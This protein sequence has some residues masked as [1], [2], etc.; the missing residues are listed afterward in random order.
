LPNKQPI[1]AHQDARPPQLTW[2]ILLPLLIVAGGVLA[3]WNSFAGVFIFDDRLWIIGDRRL[4][5]LW[6]LWEVLG[7]RRPVVDYSLALNRAIGGD[8]AWGFHAVNLTIHVLAG[9]ALFGIVRR[10]LSREPL[11]RRFGASSWWLATVVGLLWVVHPLQ[12]QSVNYII[13]RA[14]S[15]M[16]LFY[17]LTL[18]CVIRGTG[19]RH[20][21]WWYAAAVVASLLG[22][23]SK[24]VMVTAPLAIL[25]YDRAFLAA[26]WREVIQRRWG[27]YVALAATWGVLV[28]TGVARGVL[29]PGRPGAHV[30]FSYR[31][32]SPLGYALTQ[33]GVLLQYLKLSLLPYSLCLDYH[34]PVA[35][36][37]GQ[38]VP[39]GIALA[40]LLAATV[41]ALI[42]YP[43]VG[44]AAAWFFIVLAPTSSMIPIKDPIFEHRMYLPLASIVVLAVIGSDEALCR[45]AAR[46][47]HRDIVRRVAGAA[48][49]V[50][51]AAALVYGTIERNRVYRSEVTMWRDVL[52]KQPRNARAAENLGIS[53]LAEG[54]LGEALET[55]QE[56][57][58]ISPRSANVRN[59]LGFALVAH[60]R[61]DEAI[62]SFREAIRLKPRY[63]RALVNLGNA[64]NEKGR[65]EESIAQFTQAVLIQPNYT[66]ARLNLGN[67]YLTLGNVDDA[68]AQYT[69]IVEFDPEHAKAW[70]NLGY[71]LL[72]QAQRKIAGGGVSTDQAMFD[73]AI[74]ALE[75][76]LDL[77]PKSRNAWNN[78]GLAC[79]MQSEVARSRGDS[80]EADRKLDEAIEAFRQAL[81]VQSDFVAAHYNLA[82]ALAERG[83]DEGAIRHYV[84][85]L[86][87]EPRHLNA[88]YE[89]GNALVRRGNLDAARES[90]EQ[91]LQLDPNHVGAQRA[92]AELRARQTEDSTGQR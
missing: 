84:E 72:S 11:R 33:C 77:D 62:E 51:A 26:T 80:G 3:Y 2:R 44:F 79:V 41:W 59:G 48:L 66:D 18:Y 43:R 58:Q 74:R 86:K 56:A 89:L 61:L 81:W 4:K 82:N 32:I 73:A 9:L 45:L 24:G 55:L 57:V 23:G 13:Q 90:F 42:R 38:F 40:A 47:S 63:P 54:R 14:E 29:D 49:A 19:S 16:G 76:A 92:L 69:W 25:L 22:M 15:L 60:G 88:R 70:G 85:T 17:L 39:Q 10:T 12:T 91:I 64:L 37:A 31:G 5:V 21:W 67:S 71:A 28:F 27:L 83:D 65:T 30:G 36:A 20:G 46:L 6:P 75:K 78:L 34:W 50:L 35:R 52:A 8:N 53:L 1:P 68:I 7:R 87:L